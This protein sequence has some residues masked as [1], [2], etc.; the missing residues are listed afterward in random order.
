VANLAAGR[1]EGEITMEEIEQHLAEGM[2]N[3]RTL[4]EHVIPLL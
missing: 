3:V 2:Q 1:H 4:L